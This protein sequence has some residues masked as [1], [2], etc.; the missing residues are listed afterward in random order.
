M[1]CIRCGYVSYTEV[2]ERQGRVEEWVLL[3]RR[4]MRIAKPRYV[5]ISGN[6]DNSDLISIYTG[7]SLGLCPSCLL[8][9]AQIE[10]IRRG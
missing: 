6:F 4:G 10:N 2:I 1:H 9:E 3:E 7:G 8:T 5:R